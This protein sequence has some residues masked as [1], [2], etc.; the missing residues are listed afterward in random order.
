MTDAFE[1]N[2][3]FQQLP[4]EKYADL[5]KETRDFLDEL[6]PEEVET[7]RKIARL[8]KDGTAQLLEA[9]KLAQSVM[10]VGRFARWA[11]IGLLGVFFGAV[12]LAE[13]IMQVVSWFSSGGS[14]K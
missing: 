13:K 11:I 12:L 7:I 10:T 3:H 8:G 4:S 9:I 6:R 5:P 1:P 14:P 2:D